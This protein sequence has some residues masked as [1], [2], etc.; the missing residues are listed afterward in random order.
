MGFFAKSRIWTKISAYLKI[1]DGMN[2]YTY[3]SWYA[4]PA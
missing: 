3:K 4:A 1:V 2:V